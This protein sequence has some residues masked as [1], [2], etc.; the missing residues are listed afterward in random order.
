[1]PLMASVKALPKASAV[2]G[3]KAVMVGVGGLTIK[4]T[5]SETPPVVLTVMLGVP[6]EVM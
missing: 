1:M 4:G 6:A 3:L 5:A 2:A